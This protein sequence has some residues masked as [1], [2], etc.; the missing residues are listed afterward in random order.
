MDIDDA[1]EEVLDSATHYEA[2][3]TLC[4]EIDRLNGLL[5]PA[6]QKAVDALAESARLRIVLD[7]CRPRDLTDDIQHAFEVLCTPRDE[8]DDRYRSAAAR[9][10]AEYQRLELTIERLRPV[11][12]AAEVWIDRG[13]RDASDND[14]IDAIVAYQ[15]SK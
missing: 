12:E 9:V 3:L 11:V 10:V 8:D 7:I 5:L 14:L 2:G 6:Q 15:G 1:R 13:D 4:N